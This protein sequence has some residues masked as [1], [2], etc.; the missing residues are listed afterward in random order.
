MTAITRFDSAVNKYL[1]LGSTPHEV[2]YRESGLSVLKY[3]PLEQQKESERPPPVVLIPSLINKHYILDLLPGRSFVEYLVSKGLPVYL[4][5]WDSPMDEDRW[6]TADR[7]IGGRIH[8]SIRAVLRESE[9]AKVSLMGQCLGG[10][11]AAAYAIR[12][13]EMV[14]GL[15]LLTAPVDFKKTGQLA[16][17]AQDPH[18]DLDAL[19]EAY[20]NVP[21]P[22]MQAAFRLMKPAAQV[23]KYIRALPK[24]LDRTFMKGFLALEAWSRDNTSFPGSC[25]QTLIQTFYRE[26]GIVNGGLSVN[27]RKL[28]LSDLDLPVLNISAHGD[29]IVP[30][31]T[32]LKAHHLSDAVKFTDRQVGGGHIGCL[33]SRKSQRELW[34]DIANWLECANR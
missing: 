30:T 23:A 21:W 12:Y 22:L 28:K 7:L 2:I 20:G 19:T 26:N 34:P 18:I 6:L 11:L 9:H 17:W 8:R 4:I 25:Y 33:L 31:E 1:P 3:L 32:T 29:D 15:T 16:I 13:P 10:T 24:S 27:G 5:R 14:A